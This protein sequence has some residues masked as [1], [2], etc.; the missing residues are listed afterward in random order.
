MP[1]FIS[2][3][4]N[5]FTYMMSTISFTFQ[6]ILILRDLIYILPTAKYEFLCMELIALST[7]LISNYGMKFL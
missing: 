6:R 2:T 4:C 7:H 1:L 5:Y 3:D